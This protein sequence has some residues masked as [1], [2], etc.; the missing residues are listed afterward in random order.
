MNPVENARSR[1]GTP[2]RHQGRGRDGMD[3]IGLLV[4]CFPVADRADYDRNPRGGKLEAAV[5][6]SFGPPIPK[7]EMRAGDVVLMAFPSVIRHVGIVADHWTGDLS[8][9]HTWSGGPRKVCE[10]RLDEQWLARIRLVHRWS[11]V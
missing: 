10:T 9:I 2:W 8:V 1:I 4:A 3:C 6:E 11:N 7:A 5:R